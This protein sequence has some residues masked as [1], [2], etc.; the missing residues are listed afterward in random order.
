MVEF[1]S[2]VGYVCFGELRTLLSECRRKFSAQERHVCS[3]LLRFRHVLYI[4]AAFAPVKLKFPLSWPDL[5]F[6]YVAL[7]LC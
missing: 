1:V 7:N 2:Y 4:A 3:V 6:Y 5:L